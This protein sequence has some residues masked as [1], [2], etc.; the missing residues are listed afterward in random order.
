MQSPNTVPLA[1]FGNQVAY[2]AQATVKLSVHPQGKKIPPPVAPKPVKIT[3]ATVS[4]KSAVDEDANKENDK[5]E[6][7]V[8]SG[9]PIYDQVKIRRPSS[10]TNGEVKPVTNEYTSTG[11]AVPKLHLK[12]NRRKSVEDETNDDRK[13]S[14]EEERSESKEPRKQKS[15]EEELDELES[16][17]KAAHNQQ[18]HVANIPTENDNERDSSRA[19]SKSIEDELAELQELTDLLE[20]ETSKA[21]K[22]EPPA[23][24][25]TQDVIQNEQPKEEPKPKNV[26]LEGKK[27]VGDVAGELDELTN[28]LLQGLDGAAQEENFVGKKK[29]LSCFFLK[30]VEQLLAG[31]CIYCERSIL[32]LAGN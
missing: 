12:Q 14:V 5:R 25:E 11:Y 29:K 4:F 30:S 10:E 23:K 20:M 18:N 1:N 3:R 15:I 8:K 28:M 13:K 27:D 9:N 22:E 7:E 2:Q 16:L 21:K 6:S 32:N 26:G 19:R 24:T 31:F 17:A